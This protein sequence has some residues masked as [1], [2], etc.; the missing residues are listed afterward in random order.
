M[1]FKVKFNESRAVSYVT[2]N[3]KS[4]LNKFIV[5]NFKDIKEIQPMNESVR[6]TPQLVD[7][8][9]KDLSRRARGQFISIQA[10]EAVSY[11][12]AQNDSWQDVGGTDNAA[13]DVI[14]DKLVDKADENGFEL[15]DTAEYD[16]LF[17]LPTAP[18][19]SFDVMM[20]Q[21]RAKARDRQEQGQEAA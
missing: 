8:A 12:Y 4:Q 5:E 19:D 1:K 2:A 14:W 3:S 17:K 15:L 20:S 18:Q 7:A 6:V 9:W 10:L 13:F 16:E 21:R 11:D